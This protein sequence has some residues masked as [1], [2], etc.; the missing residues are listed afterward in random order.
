MITGM[1]IISTRLKQQ[2]NIKG[3]TMKYGN[4][5]NAFGYLTE[6]RKGFK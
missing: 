2:P 1:F 4:V 5:D 6:W 3:T